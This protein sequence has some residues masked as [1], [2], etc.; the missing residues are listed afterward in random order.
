MNNLQEIIKQKELQTIKDILNL[1]NEKKYEELMSAIENYFDEYKYNELQKCDRC[2][3]WFLRNEGEWDTET[4]D[5]W[6]CFD[7]WAYMEAR[8]DWWRDYLEEE[9]ENN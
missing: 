6:Y 9:A 1:L 2:Q 3:K 8:A 7:C 4:D 5:E